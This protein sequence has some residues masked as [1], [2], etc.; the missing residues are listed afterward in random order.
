MELG[1]ERVQELGQV[2]YFRRLHLLLHRPYLD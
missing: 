2:N 1:L